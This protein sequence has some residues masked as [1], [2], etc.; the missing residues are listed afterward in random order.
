MLREII[1]T[2]IYT[3]LLV[4]CLLLVSITK[5]LYPKRF[6]DFASIL[7]NYRYL[8]IYARDQKF[9][10]TFEALLFSNLV[11][12]IS[13][14]GFVSYHLNSH[15]DPSSQ[16][17]LYKLAFA[18]LI[19]I[20]VKILMERLVSSILKMDSIISEYL[21][22]KISYK[23]FIGLLL[24]PLNALLIYTLDVTQTIIITFVTLLL[25]INLIG[26]LIFIKDNLRLL[27][28]NLFYFILYLC[29]LEISP[30]FILYKLIT[31]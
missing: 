11:I 13:I 16:I 27:K 29:T 8:K 31:K 25:L 23:T 17:T 6:R 9:P 26:I 14:L 3:V 2:E 15:I 18:I 28:N 5:L 12:G 22:V 10:D 7:I 30:Y 20:T 21:F 19:I 4:L 1:S 24:I